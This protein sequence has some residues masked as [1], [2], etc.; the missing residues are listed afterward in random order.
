MSRSKPP[1]YI[2]IWLCFAYEDSGRKKSSSGAGMLMKPIR[3]GQLS[4]RLFNVDARRFPVFPPF[5]F[6]FHVCSSCGFKGN[7]GLVDCVSPWQFVRLVG[8]V[9]H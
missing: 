1:Y 3:D 7:G 5:P 9:V 2:I 6:V 4:Q 8:C